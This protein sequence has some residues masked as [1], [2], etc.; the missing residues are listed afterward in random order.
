MNMEKISQ[1]IADMKAG[2]DES[3]KNLNEKMDHILESAVTMDQLNDR[4]NPVEK[5]VKDL[6]KV[7]QELQ[8]RIRDLEEDNSKQG[9]Y[10]KESSMAKILRDQRTRIFVGRAVD[11]KR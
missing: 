9:R 1:D 5:T 3:M 4:M 8:Q 10:A 7:T 11:P 2:M 6:E